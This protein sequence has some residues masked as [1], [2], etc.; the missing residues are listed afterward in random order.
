[1][2]SFGFEV[3]MSAP[4]RERPEHTDHETPGHA[5]GLF[6]E[7]PCAGGLF[8]GSDASVRGSGGEV[9]DVGEGRG[10]VLPGKAGPQEYPNPG[11]VLKPKKGHDQGKRRS[12]GLTRMCRSRAPSRPHQ[13]CIAA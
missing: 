3:G 11:A 13:R 2:A 1:M 10:I 8:P 7:T 9:R 6:T 5:R 4:V 12:C